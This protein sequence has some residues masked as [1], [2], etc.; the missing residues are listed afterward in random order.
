MAGVRDVRNAALGNQ[1]MRDARCG[2]SPVTSSTK[3]HYWGRAA[4]PPTAERT[5][6]AAR[7]HQAQ[8]NAV[9]TVADD[10]LIAGVDVS[11][12]GGTMAVVHVPQRLRCAIVRADSR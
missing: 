4:T 6:N 10:P 3:P 8:T 12:G 5:S 7:S 1:L 9:Y 2:S 11:G